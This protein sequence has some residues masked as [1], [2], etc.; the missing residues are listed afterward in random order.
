MNSKNLAMGLIVLAVIALAVFT[1]GSKPTT[2]KTETPTPTTAEVQVDAKTEYKDGTYEAI[3][4]YTSPA[5]KEE[6]AISLTLKDG[7]VTDATFEGKGV[8]EISK[9][10]QGKFKEGF[11]EEVVGKPLDEIALTVVNGSSLTP[12]GFM[13]AVEKIKVEAQQS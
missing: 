2:Q 12:K 4:N 6:V 1:L 5:Q 8:H 3:G 9:K 7:L 10:M 11:T 13:E